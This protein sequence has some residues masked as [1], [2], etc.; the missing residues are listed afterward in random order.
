MRLA[1]VNHKARLNAEFIKARL[2]RGFSNVHDL[3]HDINEA[4]SNSWHSRDS[5]ITSDSTQAY[6]D[7]DWPHPRWVR[8]NTLRTSFKEQLDTTFAEYEPV[9]SVEALLSQSRAAKNEKYLYVD[10]HVPDLIAFS[11]ITDF[12]K[13]AA[14]RE[15]YI[16]LQDKASC[17]PALL[18]GHPGKGK[19][20]LD[21]CA[22]PGNK[23][24]HIAALTHPLDCRPL[25]YACERDKERAKTLQSMISS[26]GAD[27][28]VHLQAGQDFLKVGSADPMWYDVGSILLDP[29]CS[30]SGIV[31][32]D[33]KLAITLPKS[34]HISVSSKSKKRKRK[35]SIPSETLKSPSAQE[36]IA[37][38]VK[39]LRCDD[40]RLSALASIQLKMLEHAFS[41]PQA[42]RIT[43][44]TCSVYDQ[45][46]E[47]VVIKALLST[48]A[49]E[50]GWRILPRDD[51]VESLGAWNIRGR[52]KA[53]EEALKSH[54]NDNEKVSAEEVANACIRCEKGT[55]EGTQGF[56][57]A[58]F[59]RS[60]NES[61]ASDGAQT[62]MPAAA[63][64]PNSHFDV[65][66]EWS[67]F[68][69]DAN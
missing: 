65:E 4:S 8:V 33:A 38:G 24:T 6:A 55:N 32:R 26:A 39:P 40:D 28:K 34:E 15:G 62:A 10:Q 21:A 5:P 17:F 60:A 7:G 54:S 42:T 63:S 14:Y 48:S 27:H 59:E 61:S 51:Q 46:N 19:T 18:L 25:I 52:R 53:C 29:S 49:I 64:N 13:T 37:D 36:D 56:F 22:A 41:F 20:C 3:R 35:P 68:S 2:R 23:T 1:A 11:P 44:S 58:A 9:T 43:Y 12:T 50:R 31:G 57:V 69:D 45:E 66:E 47:H 30:G 16:I 67:G